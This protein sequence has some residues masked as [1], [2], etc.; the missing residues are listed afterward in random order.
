MTL[1]YYGAESY[2]LHAV[3][4]RAAAGEAIDLLAVAEAVRYQPAAVT[5]F[6]LGLV[7]LAVGGVLAGVAVWRSGVLPRASGIAFAA[8]FA[9]FL[10]QFYL[11]PAGRIAHGALMLVGLVWLAGALWAS[12]PREQVRAS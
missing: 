9:L 5:T 8:G 2:G 4:T 3:A 10:P 1:P 11:P 6:G 7:L 12:A